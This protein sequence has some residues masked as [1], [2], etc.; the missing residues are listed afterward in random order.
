MVASSSDFVAG[1]ENGS[2]VVQVNSRLPEE[3]A[4]RIFLQVLD[5][6]DYCHRR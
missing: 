6:V 5:A 3:E 2:I 4:R 1:T